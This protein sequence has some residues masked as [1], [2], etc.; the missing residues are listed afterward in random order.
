MNTLDVYLLLPLHP[1]P[2]IPPLLSQLAWSSL[3]PA[4]PL[5]R[6]SRAEEHD[7]AWVERASP[8][9]KSGDEMQGANPRKHATGRRRRGVR[10]ELKA[11]AP[12]RVWSTGRRALGDR[13]LQHGWTG[14]G[15]APCLPFSCSGGVGLQPT[16]GQLHDGGLMWQLW[17]R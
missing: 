13:D 1:D 12:Y 11:T 10:G 6:R 9:L 14:D 4:H 2:H 5:R 3:W 8:A 16:M 17:Q 15:G 7:S